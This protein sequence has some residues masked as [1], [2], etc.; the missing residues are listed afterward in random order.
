MNCKNCNGTHHIQQCGEI[1]A[2]L[3]QPFRPGELP[4]DRLRKA[5]DSAALALACD[6]CRASGR[7]ICSVCAVWAEPDRYAVSED[8]V[9]AALGKRAA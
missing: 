1:L 4:E 3:M 5:L 2:A 8:T 6:E 9:R 7:S